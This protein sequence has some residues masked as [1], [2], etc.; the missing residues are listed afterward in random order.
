MSVE[1]IRRVVITGLG[2]ISPNASNIADFWATILAGQ[3]AAGPLTRFPAAGAPVSIACEIRDFEPG[4]FM[5]AK[6]ARRLDPSIQF[7]IAASIL[8][9]RDSGLDIAAVEP[10]ISELLGRAAGP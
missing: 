3:S 7:A 5:D 8:A 9:V 10:R 6:N 2:V 4:K 1:G